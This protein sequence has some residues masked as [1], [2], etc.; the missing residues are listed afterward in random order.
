MSFLEVNLKTT[1][2]SSDKRVS[3]SSSISV[4]NF[5]KD[6]TNSKLDSIQDKAVSVSQKQVRSILK[7]SQ[8][9]CEQSLF[10]DN[11]SDLSDITI[12][13]L[14]SKRNQDGKI[15]PSRRYGCTNLS[16]VTAHPETTNI[17]KEN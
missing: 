7:N 4:K 1:S 16:K 11:S 9:D 14:P 8:S 17:K 13:N 3:W 2:T 10:S 15:I 6:L 5:A 12:E